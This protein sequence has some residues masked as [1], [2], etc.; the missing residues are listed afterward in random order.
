MGLIFKTRSFA[1]YTGGEKKSIRGRIIKE[2]VGHGLLGAG[3]GFLG[4]KLAGKLATPKKEIFIEKYLQSNPKATKSEA[5]EV[6]KQRLAKFNKVGAITGGV[7][8]AG[9]GAFAG[10][11]IGKANV[12]ADRDLIKSANSMKEHAERERKALERAFKNIFPQPLQ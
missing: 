11:H 12:R 3:V 6:Y 10:N 4:G 9:V 7:L 8:G 2:A 1:D 5:E